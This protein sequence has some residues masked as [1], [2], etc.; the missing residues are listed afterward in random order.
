MQRRLEPV[1]LRNVVDGVLPAALLAD[2]AVVEGAVPEGGGG[3][4]E[5]P[6]VGE[7]HDGDHANLDEGFHAE[8]EREKQKTYQLTIERSYNDRSLY[9]D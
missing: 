9:G 8:E 5:Q 2:L 6:D 3:D 4:C 1:I 7:L